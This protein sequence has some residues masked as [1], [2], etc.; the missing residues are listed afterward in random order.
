MGVVPSGTVGFCEICNCNLDG[1]LIKRYSIAKGKIICLM[2]YNKVRFASSQTRAMKVTNMSAGEVKSLV[3]KCDSELEDYNGFSFKRSINQNILVDT[4][5]RKWLIL[6]KL[7]IT[8]YDFSEIVDVALL[9]N[10][11]AVTSGG[12]GGALVGGLLFGGAGAIVGSNVRKKTT[13]TICGSLA[14]KISISNPNNP[15]KYIYFIQ[16][17]VETKSPLYRQQYLRGQECVSIFL[18]MM[19]S[20]NRAGIS[21][22]ANTIV[23][24]G[25]DEILKYKSLLDSGSITQEEFNA[26]KN[27]ILNL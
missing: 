9:E 24:S 14:V 26:K 2:C 23:P 1:N 18:S 12:L 8:I 15:V 22:S 4:V 19:E 27:Q 25:A 10:R 17:A 11:N 16:S 6:D 21:G 13:D 7:P 20:S 3:T 5:N